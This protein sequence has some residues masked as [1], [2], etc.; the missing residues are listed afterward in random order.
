MHLINLGLRVVFLYLIILVV[1]RVMGKKELGQLSMVDFVVSIMIAELAIMAI[2]NPYIAM[3]HNIY[4]MIV[5]MIIQ[6]ILSYLTLKFKKFRDLVDGEPIM[7]IVDG[8]INEKAMRRNR[9]NFDDLLLQLRQ[10]NVRYISEVEYAI[11]ETNGKLSVLTKETGKKHMT[12]P[13]ILDGEIQYKNLDRI[14][15]NEE[16]LREQ[17]VNNQLHSLSDIS[18]CSW[19]NEDLYYDLYN[20]K[21]DGPME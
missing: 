12:L 21:E 8:K 18:F 16:W 19:E 15:K 3:I 17:L 7:I 4:P 10:N 11:L 5:L 1:L 14:Q 20:D 2:E 9:Y 6:V 13:L